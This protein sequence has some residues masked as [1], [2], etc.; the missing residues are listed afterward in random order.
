M[1]KVCRIFD[2]K[3]K[4][5]PLYAVAMRARDALSFLKDVIELGR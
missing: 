3:D 5:L 4:L 1:Q 2:Q